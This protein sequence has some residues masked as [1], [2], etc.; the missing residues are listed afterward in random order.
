MFAVC[1]GGG[2]GAESLEV[3]SFCFMLLGFML[4]L[5]VGEALFFSRTLARLLNAPVTFAFLPNIPGGPGV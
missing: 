5:F 4:L 1:K 2:F 3:E